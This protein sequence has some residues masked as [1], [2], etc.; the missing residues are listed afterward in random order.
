MEFL[1]LIAAI[2]L[3][4]AMLYAPG[5]PLLRVAGLSRTWSTCAAPA[6]SCFIFS[7]LSLAYCAAGIPCNPATIVLAPVLIACAIL[8]IGR[9][10][11]DSLALPKISW[12]MVAAFVAIG[13][14]AGYIVFLRIL[15]DANS[16]AQA[17]DNQ[18]HINGI[19]AFAQSQTFDSLHQTSYQAAADFDLNPTPDASYYPSTWLAICAMI[20]QLLNVTGGLAEN[21][22]NFSF[23]AI[24]FPL[25]MLAFLRVALPNERKLMFAGAIAV[26]AFPLFPWE[27]L[28]YGPLFPNLASFA[29]M[30]VA[31]AFAALCTKPGTIKRERA[32]QGTLFALVCLG[33]LFLQ[34]N[35]IFTLALFIAPLLVQNIAGTPGLQ[36]GGKRIPGCAC[37]VLF[38]AF[39]IGV[40]VFA[41]LAP[42]SALQNVIHSGVWHWKFAGVREAIENVFMLSYIDD[43]YMSNAQLVSGV[44]VLIGIIRTLFKR[45]QLWISITYILMCVIVIASMSFE[46]PLKSFF[47][48]FWYDDPFRCGSMASIAAIPLLVLG[49]GWVIDGAR[50]TIAKIL[51]ANV[52]NNNMRLQKATG[53]VACLCAAAFAVATFAPNFAVSSTVRNDEA[54]S[55]ST[56]LSKWYTFSEGPYDSDESRFVQKVI[57]EIGTDKLVINQPNDGS[58]FSYGEE[59]LRTYYRRFNGY[60][61]KDET[62]ASRLIRDHLNNVAADETV[63]NACSEI[64]AEYVMV[65]HR[66]DMNRSFIRG[67]YWEGAWRGIDAITDN[68]PG[69]EVVLQDGDMRLYRITCL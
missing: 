30:P 2:L 68:T 5:Y 14:V 18:H 42:I 4:L 8:F 67:Q 38:A 32:T 37:A 60:G 16:F 7:V 47:S 46:E 65:L 1:T 57:Q 49:A 55:A 61:S 13:C 48:G 15:P 43:F 69:L 3:T 33:S 58:V 20:L 59:G 26:V 39:C 54:E 56:A 19:R 62:N 28:S 51:A 40:W 64:G 6:I 11:R 44:L 29:C 12:P 34:P 21:A 45:E 10:N 41:Y 31:L 27:M 63:K 24:V 53:A 23:A 35:S 9:N 50:S 17:W 25:S 22:V 36:I 52:E 66:M